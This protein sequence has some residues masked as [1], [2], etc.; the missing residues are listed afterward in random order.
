MRSNIEYTPQAIV[1]LDNAYDGVLEES[2]DKKTADKYLSDLITKIE[3]KREFPLS[4]PVF[5]FYNLMLDIHHF[6]F[7]A[8]VIFYKYENNCIRVLRV[9][10]SKMDYMKILKL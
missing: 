6:T 4:T 8:Y 10:P 9:L 2:C 5:D 3:K 7:K 1:D